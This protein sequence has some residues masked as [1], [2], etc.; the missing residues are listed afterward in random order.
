MKFN[1][2]TIVFSLSLIVICERIFFQNFLKTISGSKHF[3]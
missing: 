3:S 2:V 1:I